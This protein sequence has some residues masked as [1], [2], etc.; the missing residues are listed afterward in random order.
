[1][2]LFLSPP[3]SPSKVAVV[4]LSES[5]H[6]QLRALGAPI[7][8]SVLCPSW[9]RARVVE[10]DRNRPRLSI[11]APSPCT[12][13][14]PDRGGTLGAQGSSC[15]RRFYVLA[16]HDEDHLALVR[17]RTADIIEEGSPALPAI[18]G[19]G[20]V[21]AASSGSGEFGRGEATGQ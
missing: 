15:L 4:A 12:L 2:N 5:L 6:F 11:P 9:V 7:G 17:Q 8:V 3:Y 18:P 14:P 20:P 1:M 21:L 10:S 16:H 13:L 19:I